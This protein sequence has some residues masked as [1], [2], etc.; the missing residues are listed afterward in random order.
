MSVGAESADQ[1]IA[2]LYTLTPC[3]NRVDTDPTAYLAACFDD[4]DAAGR[5]GPD[6]Q[7]ET[8]TDCLLQF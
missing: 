4:S 6:V 1:S 8:G 5:A 3:C 7:S 2:A